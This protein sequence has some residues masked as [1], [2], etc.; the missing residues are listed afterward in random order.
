MQTENPFWLNEAYKNPIN[1]SDTG[2]ITRNFSLSK[3]IFILFLF[4]FD[5]KNK[6]L[7]Y[8]GGY[9]ITTRI[10]RD[11]G[12]D[13]YWED[14][15]VK[16]LFAK[17][18]EYKNQNIKAISCL[19]CFEH[20]VNPKSE[21]KKILTI[22]K[23]VFFST[24]LLDDSKVPDNSWWY[25][26]FEHG[27]HISFYSLKTLKYLA[28]KNNLFLCSNKKTLHLFLE[29]KLNNFIFLFL[30]KLDIFP[31]DSLARLFTKSKTWSDHELLKNL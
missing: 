8:A 12:L 7:D 15:Y 14:K 13:F 24:N 10:L 31:W 30:I 23:N 9:G 1:I 27:Q 2:Y 20:F 25:Y 11:F 18:F 22:S 17:G 28:R 26:G 4:L 3:K 5:K 6:F 29:K 16:N 19:E 21:I